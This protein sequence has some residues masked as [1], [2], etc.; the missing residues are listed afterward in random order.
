MYLFNLNIR[1]EGERG[2]YVFSVCVCVCVCV[3]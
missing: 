2:F 1:S 3:C